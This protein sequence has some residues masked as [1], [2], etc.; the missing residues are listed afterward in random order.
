MSAE[1]ECS[2][3]LNNINNR[4]QDFVT[5]QCNHSFHASCLISCVI[6]NGHECPMCRTNMTI[7]LVDLTIEE[8]TNDNEI[9]LVTP[10][11]RHVDDLGRVLIE[12]DSSDEE[13]E[14]EDDE[15]SKIYVEK[16]IFE[17]RLVLVSL[18][19]DTV[20]DYN[21]YVDYGEITSVGTWDWDNN[22]I[23]REIV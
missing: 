12:V 14:E 5:T 11:P 8:D 21:D 15:L 18:A 6:Q 20:F 23:L 10:L 7:P 1:L 22:A 13:E 17:D 3:C 19:S 9:T 4:A 16:H 2:I